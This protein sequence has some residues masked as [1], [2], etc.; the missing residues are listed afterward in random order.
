M[1]YYAAVRLD[2]HDLNRITLGP[3]I[4]RR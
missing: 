2:M 3:K 1:T 4:G